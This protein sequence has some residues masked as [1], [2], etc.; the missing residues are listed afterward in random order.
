MLS[1]LSLEAMPIRTQKDVNLGYLGRV[2]SLT[3]HTSDFFKITY[4]G[5]KNFLLSFVSLDSLIPDKT[6]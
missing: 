5:G 1:I 6:K 2:S 3:K 4:M